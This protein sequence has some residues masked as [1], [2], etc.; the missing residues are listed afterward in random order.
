MKRFA[1]MGFTE[2]EIGFVIA[3]LF[4]AIAVATLND[5]DQALVTVQTLREV[6]SERDRVVEEFRVY[7]VRAEEELARLR[8]A[9]AKQSTKVPQCWEM[10]QPRE[11]VADVTVMGD[12][13]YEMHGTELTIDGITHA[14]SE[15]IALGSKL[16]CR[17][18]LR[19]RPTPGVDA[20]AQSTAVWRLRRFFDV[21]D[22]PR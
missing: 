13:R 7:K 11:P 17:F 10:D 18:V 19:A 16:G 5:R 8:G 9:A 3:A 12:N 14:L 15:K 22:R 4:A 21:D 2:A 1:V 20:I 6:E